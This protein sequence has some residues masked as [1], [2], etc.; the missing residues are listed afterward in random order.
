[1]EKAGI[2]LMCAVALSGCASVTGSTNQS[3]S[4][5]TRSQAGGEIRGVNCELTNN[6]GK[7]FVTTPGSIMVRRS[8]DDLQ[9]LCQRPGLEPGRTNVVSTTM[10]AMFGNILIGGIIGAVV[11]HSNGSAYEYPPFVQVVMGQPATGDASAVL[12]PV[13][14]ADATTRPIPRN[15][16]E[17]KAQELARARCTADPRPYSMAGGPGQAMEQFSIACDDGRQM[18]VRCDAGDCRELGQ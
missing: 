6:K 14:V 9:V 13:T 2:A 10:P 18:R 16:N 8:N 15:P 1:M 11:D 5:Q 17:I 4:V 7:W 12:P 3:L